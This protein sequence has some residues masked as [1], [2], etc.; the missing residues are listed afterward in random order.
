MNRVARTCTRRLAP[1]H[2]R[3]RKK[4]VGRRALF[5]P[6]AASSS[7]RSAHRDVDCVSCLSR[8]AIP[9]R[10][11][12]ATTWYALGSLATLPRGAPG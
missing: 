1:P 3:F 9:R 12:N 10:N 11:K 7:E 4:A 6:E 2:P 5:G 8:T